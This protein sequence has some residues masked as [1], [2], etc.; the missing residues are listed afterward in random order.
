MKK[1][2]H[3]CKGKIDP[4]DTHIFTSA[5]SP[6]ISS[7]HAHLSSLTHFVFLSFP[8]W[9]NLHQ[10]MV[11]LNGYSESAQSTLSSKSF[12]NLTISKEPQEAVQNG[13]FY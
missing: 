2:I 10:E 6:R 8:T 7:T 13:G 9:S 3:H 11:E 1:T 4:L 12:I 5:N